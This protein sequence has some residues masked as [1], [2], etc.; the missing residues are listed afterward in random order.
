MT[1][2]VEILVEPESGITLGSGPWQGLRI[3]YRQEGGRLWEKFLVVGAAEQ[4]LRDL[5]FAALFVV[6]HSDGRTLLP[7]GGLTVDLET[8]EA[9]TSSEPPEQ[10]DV[11]SVRV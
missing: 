7:A 4:S 9:Q 2:Q 3:R 6:A 8:A 5:L 10:L 1:G 11:W